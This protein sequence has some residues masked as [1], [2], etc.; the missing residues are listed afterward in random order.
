MLMP[1]L[2]DKWNYLKDED[3]DLFPLLEVGA[4]CWDK[5]L[6]SS[7]GMGFKVH[8]HS[9]LSLSKTLHMWYLLNQ[10]VVALFGHDCKIHGW[11]VKAQNKDKSCFSGQF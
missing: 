4:L 5:T 1:P 2:I 8:H 7:R 11:K 9:I 10:E 6:S 3:K